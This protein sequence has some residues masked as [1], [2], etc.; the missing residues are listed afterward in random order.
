M[1][2]IRDDF[3]VHLDMLS[4]HS[5]LERKSKEFIRINSDITPQCQSSSGV[6]RLWV[7]R[8]PQCD[9]SHLSTGNSLGFF[10]ELEPTVRKQNSG[11]QRRRKVKGPG[12][13]GHKS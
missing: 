8:K 5:Q 13:S 6:L 12:R 3:K 10:Q 4:C 11:T 1:N 2:Q 9:I 7:K